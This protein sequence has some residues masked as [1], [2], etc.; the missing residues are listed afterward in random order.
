V[1]LSKAIFGNVGN[2]LAL[3]VGSIDAQELE[4]EFSPEFSAQDLNNMDKHR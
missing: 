4:N 1:D 3:K 2:M